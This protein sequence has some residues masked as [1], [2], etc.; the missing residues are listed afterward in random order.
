MHRRAE[1]QKL[2]GP[3]YCGGAGPGNG[4]E[5]PAADVQHQIVDGDQGRIEHQDHGQLFRDRAPVEDKD[6]EKK[7]CQRSRQVY[8]VVCVNDNVREHGTHHIGGQLQEYVFPKREEEL[9]DQKKDQGIPQ[10][11]KK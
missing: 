3:L 5:D 10:R 2:S 11:N 9:K 7:Q 4:K 8:D 6:I 1:Q